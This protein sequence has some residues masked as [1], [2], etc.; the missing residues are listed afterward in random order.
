MIKKRFLYK[1]TII[2]IISLF[3]VFL[4]IFFTII[5]LQFVDQDHIRAN[6]PLNVNISELIEHP[7]KYH[8]QRIRV[9]GFVK[10]DI[11]EAA[12]Y[13]NLNNA[14][15]K[16]PYNSIWIELQ[17]FKKYAEYNKK[18]VAVIGTF[19]KFN[20]G[21]D[22]AYLGSIEKIEFIFNPYIEPSR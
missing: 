12:I 13:Q 6:L 1:D 9:E 18:L 11:K 21:K 15:G 2:L 10:I 20:Y 5:Y 8:E 3:F 22:K 16:L 4:T 14:S 17:D 7:D 19:N